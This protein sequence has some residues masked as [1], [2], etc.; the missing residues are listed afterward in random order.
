[1]TQA[2]AE[3]PALPPNVGGNQRRVELGRERAPWLDAHQGHAPLRFTGLEAVRW[4]FGG[5]HP[6]CSVRYGL[7]SLSQ[8]RQGVTVRLEDPGDREVDLARCRQHRPA[9]AGLTA[10]G[11]RQQPPEVL[12]ELHGRFGVFSGTP[13]SL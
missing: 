13:A 1:M 5:E 7:A 4:R 2:D 10:A 12:G 11:L 8:D 6:P 9:L 3:Q